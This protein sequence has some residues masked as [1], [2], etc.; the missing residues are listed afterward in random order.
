MQFGFHMSTR[1]ATAA[2][3]NI[4]QIASLCDRLGFAVFGVN[5][6][7]VV[8]TEISS[9]YPYSAD[10]SWAGAAQGTCLETLA[11]L[12]FIAAHTERIRLLS[13]VL[14]IPHRPPVLTA[15]M[16]ATVDILSNGRLTVGAGVGWMREEL[17]ALGAPAYERRGR[18]SHEYIEAFRTLWTTN[19]PAEYHGEFVDFSGVVFEPKPV[20]PGGPPL[21][22]GGEGTAARERAARYADGWYPVGRNPRYPLDTVARFSEGL[23]DVRKRAEGAGRDPGALEVAMYAPWNRLGEEVIEDGQRL[24]F[25]GSAQAI[26]DDVGAF[27]AA[28]L[29]TLLVNLE[30]TSV[31]ETTE[32]CEAFAE[33]VMR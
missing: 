21:W 5:D 31:A 15:K 1:G 17:N 6:H 32:R 24:P 10:G 11:T 12:G 2:P 4:A 13:S 16:L 26:I 22:I 30:G 9:T 14:V 20:Q 25:T 27:E 23:A 19:G 29:G 18:A 3:D 33:A 28:G 7:V 8:T